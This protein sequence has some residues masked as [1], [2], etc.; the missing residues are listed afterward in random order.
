ARNEIKRRIAMQSEKLGDSG[1]SVSLG[2]VID[3]IVE[4]MVGSTKVSLKEMQEGDGAGSGG[5][6]KL[7]LPDFSGNK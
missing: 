1:E 6:P 5:E 4:E 2:A 7:S 3:Q